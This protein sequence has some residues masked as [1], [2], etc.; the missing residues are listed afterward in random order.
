VGAAIPWAYKLIVDRGSPFL[1]AHE[2]A[3]H[4]KITALILLGIYGL[5]YVGFTA[6]FGIPEARNVVDRV[7]RLLRLSVRG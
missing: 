5:T 6:A 3:V 7:R 1:S 2:N 4:S